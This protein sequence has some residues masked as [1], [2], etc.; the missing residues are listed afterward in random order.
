MTTTEATP[1]TAEQ[2]LAAGALFTIILFTLAIA[3]A[4]NIVVCALIYTR[5]KRIPAEYRTMRPGLVWLLLIPLFALIWNFFVFL[6]MP[7]SFKAYF[8]AQGRTDVG[9]CGRTI[10]RWY[11]ICAVATL[12]PCVGY[13]TSIAGLILL[14]IFIVKVFDLAGKIPESEVG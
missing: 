14:I 11:A 13:F 5:F 6:R 7:E 3:L 9:D 2:L 12:V 1:G 10:G 4:I 8:D